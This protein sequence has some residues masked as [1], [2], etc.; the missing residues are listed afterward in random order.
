MSQPST[1]PTECICTTTCP[2]DPE[3]NDCPHCRTIDPYDPCPAT[4]YGC[5]TECGDDEH[6]T[7][8]QQKAADG[9]KV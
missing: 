1:K 9:N 6:C 4:G 5:G 7:P 2:E 8:E 3:D